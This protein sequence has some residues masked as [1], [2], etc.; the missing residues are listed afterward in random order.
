MMALKIPTLSVI[1]AALLWRIGTCSAYPILFES[2]HNSHQVSFGKKLNIYTKNS[3]I[4]HETVG[5]IDTNTL[6][7]GLQHSRR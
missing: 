1:A 5:K 7:H 2:I 4:L 3:D 6:V